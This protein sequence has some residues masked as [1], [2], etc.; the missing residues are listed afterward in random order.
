MQAVPS[1]SIFER[2]AL[3]LAETRRLSPVLRCEWATRA[4]TDMCEMANRRELVYFPIIH[5]A[6]DMG[7]LREQ[8]ERMKLMQ[9]GRQTLRQSTAAVDR[10]WTEIEKAVAAEPVE[11]RPVRVYQDGLPECGRELDI[12]QEL[13]RCGSRN[14]RLLLE[15][16]GRGAIIMGTE[17]PELLTEEYQLVSE[18]LAAGE[19]ARVLAV[20]ARQKPL[21]DELLRR[22]DRHI[23]GRINATLLDDDTG[24]LFIG[25]LH[26]VAALLDRDIRVRF[27]ARG[28]RN[29]GGG[30]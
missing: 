17:S 19:R 4:L 5:T 10:L 2:E 8:V 28:F 11:G 12:V 7:A 14:H 18:A 20:E 26:N 23:A 15:L 13:A 25:M 30:R 16:H 21:R 29:T 24:I 22:R 9:A 1:L 6:A 27:P 3:R